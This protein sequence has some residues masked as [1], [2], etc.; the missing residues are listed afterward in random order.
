MP[1]FDRVEMVCFNTLINS[2]FREIYG[3]RCCS[4]CS[5]MKLVVPWNL[6]YPPEHLEVDANSVYLSFSA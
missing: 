5:T 4:Q 6:R 1:G 2:Q 3:D